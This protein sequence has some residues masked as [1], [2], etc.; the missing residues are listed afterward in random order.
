M[1]A[2]N[3]HQ[4][5]PST[6]RYIHQPSLPNLTRPFRSILKTDWSTYLPW[7]ENDLSYRERTENN[8]SLINGLANIVSCNDAA[9]YISTRICVPA[10]SALILFHDL[11][12]V[13]AGTVIGSEVHVLAYDLIGKDFLVVWF[14]ECPIGLGELAM[15]WK[16]KAVELC[17]C[18]LEEICGALDDPKLAEDVSLKWEKEFGS[19]ILPEWEEELGLKVCALLLITQFL[20]DFQGPFDIDAYRVWHLK[21]LLSAWRRK[22]GHWW[23]GAKKIAELGLSDPGMLLGGSSSPI[24]DDFDG[25]GMSP[26][27]VTFSFSNPSLKK[28][29]ATSAEPTVL[30]PSRANT[31]KRRLQQCL[32]DEDDEE[33]WGAL[34]A[35]TASQQE[36]AVELAKSKPPT[37]SSRYI[38]K[39]TRYG[40]SS[41]DG[42]SST[43]T[44]TTPPEDVSSHVEMSDP[45]VA[46]DHSGSNEL[47]HRC[48]SGAKGDKE[49]TMMSTVGETSLD[50][51]SVVAMADVLKGLVE[52]RPSLDSAE[53][54]K[55]LRE[56]LAQLVNETGILNPEVQCDL[57]ELTEKGVVNGESGDE[58]YTGR[59]N[60]GE[61]P[62]GNEASDDGI[63]KEDGDGDSNSEG[64][65]VRFIDGPHPTMVIPEE[66]V[67][68]LG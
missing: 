45:E 8:V 55:K 32:Y 56:F 4:W 25:R 51:G 41:D 22:V 33:G 11:P 49:S 10:E 16:E 40:V 29:I 24:D 13:K 46:S 42:I 28:G 18:K 52:G 31:Y 23:V 44:F 27:S 37:Y 59:K 1:H 5:L 26:D 60:P 63:G 68:V 20:L 57:T 15:G 61:S 14:E 21:A 66:E 48:S 38:Y 34:E 64:K 36:L 54:Q 17:R 53:N 19:K 50:L 6:H 58:I 35:W 67:N 7:V 9:G 62:G 65:S 43:T 30:T 2:D 39:S 3:P 47:S 12:V